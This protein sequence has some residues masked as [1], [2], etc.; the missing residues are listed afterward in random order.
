MKVLYTGFKGKNNSS[1]QVLSKLSGEKVYLTNSFTGLERDIM[2]ISDDY[3]MVVMLG[4]DSHIKDMVRIESVAEYG[5][6]EEKSKICCVS[7][8]DR[9]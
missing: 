5:G 4:L 7:K 1:F 6:T 8:E 9:Q 3:D 2:K